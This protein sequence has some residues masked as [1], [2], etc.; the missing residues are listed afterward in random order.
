MTFFFFFFSFFIDPES[1]Q[2]KQT[3]KKTN[4]NAVKGIFES[5][6]KQNKIKL[7]LSLLYPVIPGCVFFSVISGRQDTQSLF[8]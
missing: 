6:S 5:S 2:T 1:V 8:D 7:D 3:Y 4:T